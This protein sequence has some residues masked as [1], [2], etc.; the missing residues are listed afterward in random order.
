MP[1]LPLLRSLC[2]AAMVVAPAATPEALLI[3]LGRQQEALAALVQR[4]AEERGAGAGRDGSINRKLLDPR[5][6]TG[7]PAYGGGDHFAQW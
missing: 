1:W 2:W 7:V 5:D 4:M 6:F 3:A